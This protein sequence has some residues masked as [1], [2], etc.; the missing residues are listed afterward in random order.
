MKSRL[1]T[2]R[3]IRIVCW[4]CLPLEILCTLYACYIFYGAVIRNVTKPIDEIVESSTI[5]T[6]ETEYNEFTGVNLFTVIPNTTTTTTA[7]NTT[8]TVSNVEI[9]KDE[10]DM[11]TKRILDAFYLSLAKYNGMMTN[12]AL[13]FLI[14]DVSRNLK[15]YWREMWFDVSIDKRSTGTV[16]SRLSHLLS[17]CSLIRRKKR[18]G[19]DKTTDNNNFSVPRNHVIF[20]VRLILA[21]IAHAVVHTA[22]T[23]P[24]IWLHEL[25]SEYK[26]TSNQTLDGFADSMK[27]LQ[28]TLFSDIETWT[29]YVLLIFFAIVGWTG[30]RLKNFLKYHVYFV[31]IHT[32]I[33]VF[34]SIVLTF[35]HSN[36]PINHIILFVFILDRIVGRW[37]R[38]TVV[39]E[40]I[41]HYPS[42]SNMIATSSNENSNSN[43]AKRDTNEIEQEVLEI[44]FNVSETFASR[45]Y[46]G[47][48][49]SVCIPYISRWQWHEFSI[50]N[51]D[52]TN[53]RRKKIIVRCVGNW[54]QR[55]FALR[56]FDT[57]KR[58]MT[59]YV[60]GPYRSWSCD[61]SIFKFIPNLLSNDETLGRYLNQRLRA[62]AR[63][64]TP[65]QFR[66]VDR[67]KALR[68]YNRTTTENDNAY[69]ERK[70]T[71]INMVRNYSRRDSSHSFDYS[72]QVE[73][74]VLVSTGTAVT[75]HLSVLD[76]LVRR[77]ELISE[78]MERAKWWCHDDRLKIKCSGLPQHIKLIW[79]IKRIEDV[80]FAIWSFNKYEQILRSKGYDDILSY[81]IWVTRP[82]SNENIDIFERV[83]MYV[84]NHDTPVTET[85]MI[86]RQEEMKLNQ[87]IANQRRNALFTTENTASPN[88]TRLPMV[89]ARTP[90]M[91]NV[92]LNWSD[93][94]D[95][96]YEEYLN[97]GIGIGEKNRLPRNYLTEQQSKMTRP[98]RNGSKAS[99]QRSDERRD[100]TLNGTT[101]RTQSSRFVVN[102]FENQRRDKTRNETQAEIKVGRRPKT[103]SIL[104][105]IVGPRIRNFDREKKKNKGRIL[106]LLQS[107][108]KNFEI[109]MRR[110]CA[111]DDRV[112]LYVDKL[113]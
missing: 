77:Y 70:M 51:A 101:K 18:R 62:E 29:G 88:R 10:N 56:Y 113:W 100:A 95:S 68:D 102:L 82:V 39:I 66:F 94:N 105:A 104:D 93:T 26:G 57:S 84:Q 67:M 97:T 69:D 52:F 74:L 98:I 30:V 36:Y 2:L 41:V 81:H 42:F 21:M 24:P 11:T 64:T 47:S 6:N 23:H 112:T 1:V 110:I 83:K 65:I 89:A 22:S 34:V 91:S 50:L 107:S 111:D 4:K 55:L 33:F 35:H 60:N 63:E 53:N 58:T 59:M 108:V 40:R 38:S 75:G 13:L 46:A 86:L 17:R 44:I 28:R 54:T 14:L 109:E 85:R 90:M 8:A 37:N 96:I 5:F 73:T 20:A 32:L 25:L 27:F 7:N 31:S 103:D 92:F 72:E 80:T 45:C 61:E 49:V 43:R 106:V 19:N 12:L 78:N 3:R 79:T 48:Y 15:E 9:V 99:S 76:E 16:A 71:T 87:Y